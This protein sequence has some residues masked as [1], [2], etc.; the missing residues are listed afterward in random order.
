MNGWSIY[1]QLHTLNPD[2]TTQCNMIDVQSGLFV[3]HVRTPQGGRFYK[4]IK[5]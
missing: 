2:L 4:L 3:L 5:Q 1:T